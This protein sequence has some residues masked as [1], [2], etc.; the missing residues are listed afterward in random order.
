MAFTKMNF[1][2]GFLFIVGIL[3][4][5]VMNLGIEFRNGDY[6]LDNKSREYIDNYAGSLTQSK[7]DSLSNEDIANKSK[8]NL[9][10][11]GNE[12]GSQSVTDFLANLNYYREKIQSTVSYVKLVYNFPTF[13]VTSLGLPIG[14]FN[15]IINVAG[16]VIFISLLILFVRMVRGS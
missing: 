11:S 2:I 14:E 8:E 1:W 6:S 15:N 9:V 16:V 10:Q 4:I 5:S 7:F 13:I 12:T 3:S